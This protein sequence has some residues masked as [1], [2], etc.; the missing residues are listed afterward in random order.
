MGSQRVSAL[1]VFKSR[2]RVS[3]DP[4]PHTAN[5]NWPQSGH[6]RLLPTLYNLAV[7]RHSIS[8]NVCSQAR[9][10][11]SPWG[12]A[13]RN[14]GQHDAPSSTS[15]ALGIYPSLSPTRTGPGPEARIAQ[16]KT[17]QEFSKPFVSLR[18][19]WILLISKQFCEAFKG[20]PID[21]IESN[22]SKSIQLIPKEFQPH[23]PI[24]LPTF[25]EIILLKTQILKQ[26]KFQYG[27]L[28][29]FVN[30]TTDMKFQ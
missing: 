13:R 30:W 16:E 17:Y 10:C 18:R 14:R 9:H 3:W 4:H 2:R 21:P 24:T 8:S 29:E 1:G 19:K 11:A 22:Q 15:S 26:E 25:I 27:T 20:I 6:G 5:L 7:G 12:T 28:F 23:L